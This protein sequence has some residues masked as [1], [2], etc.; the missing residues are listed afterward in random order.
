MGS[1]TLYWIS[2]SLLGCAAIGKNTTTIHFHQKIIRQTGKVKSCGT[3]DPGIWPRHLG[4]RERRQRGI[5][6]KEFITKWQP[7]S[8]TVNLQNIF[9]I[10]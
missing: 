7:R 10:I 5:H 3:A 1:S 4:T 2:C 6:L 9:S 8:A